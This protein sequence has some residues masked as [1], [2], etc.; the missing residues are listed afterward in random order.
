MN[1]QAVIAEN[2]EKPSEILEPTD[3]VVINNSGKRDKLKK[4]YDFNE[5][6]LN[7]FSVKS[8]LGPVLYPYVQVRPIYPPLY[9]IWYR[10][11]I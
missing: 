3:A 2:D 5:N 6:Q 4:V 11:Y 9:Y 7:K 10:K 8:R 1:S